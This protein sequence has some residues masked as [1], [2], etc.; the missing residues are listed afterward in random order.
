MDN[1]FESQL[2]TRVEAIIAFHPWSSD[3]FST[4]NEFS[5]AALVE[6]EK[7]IKRLLVEISLEFVPTLK[8]LEEMEP[9]QLDRVPSQQIPHSD[10]NLSMDQVSSFLTSM[11]NYVTDTADNIHSRPYIERLW[12]EIQMDALFIEDETCYNFGNIWLVLEHKYKFPALKALN[13]VLIDAHLP[14]KD[15]NDTPFI[16][17]SGD[18]FFDKPKTSIRELL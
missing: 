7:S 15:A 3:P 10:K 12:N 9:T 17:S 1:A 2:H 16:N 8:T 5:D 13:E 4:H 11:T 6:V 18:P 14:E